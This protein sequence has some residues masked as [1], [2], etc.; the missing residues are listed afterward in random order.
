MKRKERG[1]DACPLN[2]S[3]DEHKDPWMKDMILASILE[4][5]SLP[6]IA[7]RLTASVSMDLSQ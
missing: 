4:G 3:E 2:F 7:A 1:S 5:T 6:Q